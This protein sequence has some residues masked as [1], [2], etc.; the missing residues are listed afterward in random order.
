MCVCVCVSVY[1]YMYI[2]IYK[3]HVWA[4]HSPNKQTWIHGTSILPP[5]KTS[6]S[7]HWLRKNLDINHSYTNQPG[8]E[9][10]TCFPLK[11]SDLCL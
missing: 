3:I 1:V 9:K 4:K 2:Y 10:N 5:I 7:R 11:T 6:A 8:G